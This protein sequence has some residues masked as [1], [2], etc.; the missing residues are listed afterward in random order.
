MADWIYDLDFSILYPIVVAMS[1]GAAGIGAWLG[2]RS[3]RR[4]AKQEDLGMLA[5]STLGLLALLL[6]FSFSL[7]LSRFDTRRS[8]V[9]DEANAIGSAANFAIMLPEATRQPI[10]D[11]LREYTAVR[12]GLGRPFDPAKLEHDV[13]RSVDLQAMLWQF[14]VTLTAESPQSLPIYR[15]VGSLNE[16]NNIHESRLSA[17]RFRIP[18][19]VMVLLLG[20]AIVAMALTGYHSGVRGA[21]RPM[22]TIL[23]AMTV[24]IVMTLVVDLDRPARG[25]IQVPVQPL[26]DA[27]RALPR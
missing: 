24:A 2:T 23:T 10:L 11:L 4:G 21:R 7:A 1:V 25:F 22:A 27:A 14:A 20:V 12:T 19:E 17:I 16:M 3:Q 15:F 5:G 18:A 8:M 26:V 9:L 6:A 13:A